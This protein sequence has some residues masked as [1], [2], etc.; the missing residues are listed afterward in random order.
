ML[1]WHII[2]ING[3]YFSVIYK[4]MYIGFCP[5]RDIETKENRQVIVSCVKY[6]ENYAILYFE[7]KTAS[8][9]PEDVAEGSLVAFPDGALWFEATEIFHY[10]NI[11]EDSQWER[12]IPDK[13]SKILVNR[14]HKDKIAS[15]IYYHYE[16]QND[17]QVEVDKF[18][19]IFI[20][21][22][23]IFI[24]KELPTEE[25]T[26][27]DIEGKNHHGERYDWPALM[28]EHFMPWEDGSQ[29]W[30]DLD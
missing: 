3:R 9:V 28:N 12:K 4:H 10:F 6:Y 7:T 18:F 20:Y 27:A 26:W 23:L 24:Y 11:E 25:I 13:E 30:V 17:N 2:Y 15:Y 8:L 19:S 14:L 1:E 22:N 16:H 29:G 5:Q 21:G